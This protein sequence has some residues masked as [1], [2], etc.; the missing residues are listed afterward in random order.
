MFKHK[1]LVSVIIAVLIFVSVGSCIFFRKYYVP[2][3][4]FVISDLK[5]YRGKYG[6]DQFATR[7]AIYEGLIKNTGKRQELLKA[8]IG[9]IYSQDH[10]YLTDGYSEIS[11][12]LNPGVSIPFKLSTQVDAHDTVLRKYYDDANRLMPDIY[13]WFTTCK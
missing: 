1:L 12:S 7:Y 8:M 6:D 9:K 4:G 10:V 11:V 3:C 5:E 13:P 2:K